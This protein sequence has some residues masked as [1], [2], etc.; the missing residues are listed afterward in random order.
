[1]RYKLEFFKN[2]YYAVPV[3]AWEIWE[4]YKANLNLYE[5]SNNDLY[6]PV[7]PVMVWVIDNL[8]DFTF[9]DPQIK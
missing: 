9:T 6:E 1:M 4:F 2:V 3:Y 8:N 7:F 5:A